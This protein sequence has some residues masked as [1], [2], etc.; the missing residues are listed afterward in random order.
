MTL[1]LICEANLTGLLGA[2][3]ARIWP[4]KE[5][6]RPVAR[7][8]ALVMLLFACLACLR[9]GANITNTLELGGIAVS[10]CGTPFTHG[11]REMVFTNTAYGDRPVEQCF[12]SPFP[13]LIALAPGFLQIS[14]GSGSLPLLRIEADYSDGCGQGCTRLY[15]GE[16]G[17]LVA[18]ATNSAGFTEGTLTLEVATAVIDS[19][20]L[21][22]FEGW[23]YRLRLISAASPERVVLQVEATRTDLRLTWPLASRNCQL[24]TATLLGAA[25]NWTAVSEPP[26][27][28][29]GGMEVRLVPSDSPAWFRLKCP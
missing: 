7:F 19:V 27:E 22:T 9:V 18:M 21:S 5:R 28:T 13:N 10:Q 29:P 1:P 24:E 23:F 3:R 20:I 8:R 4:W 25:A 6:G 17:Q 16:N 14:L 26:V 12:V 15:V 11:G 2:V